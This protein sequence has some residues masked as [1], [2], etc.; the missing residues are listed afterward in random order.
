MR[1]SMR[2]QE[3]PGWFCRDCVDVRDFDARKQA[4]RDEGW[5]AGGVEDVIKGRLFSFKCVRSTRAILKPGAFCVLIFPPSDLEVAVS[6][7]SGRR[8][9]TQ[10]AVASIVTARSKSWSEARLVGETWPSETAAEYN[11]SDRA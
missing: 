8:S 4:V 6:G 9:S 7:S 3:V 1:T 5:A 11:N 2:N 10:H